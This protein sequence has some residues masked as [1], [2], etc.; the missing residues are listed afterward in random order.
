MRP[1]MNIRTPAV[2][3]VSLALIS[4][5]SGCRPVGEAAGSATRTVVTGHEGGAYEPKNTSRYA[6]ENDV[7]FVDMDY[8]T[9][10][11]VTCSGIQEHTLDDGRLE[12]AANLRNRLSRRI[13]VQ[14]QCVFKDSQGFA[15]DDSATWQDLIL[16]EAGQ[17]TVRFQSLNDK[18]KRYTLRV[19][20]A[21]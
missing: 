16:T 4:V 10:R 5:T 17:E 13:Q 14:V 6:L 2:L 21:H 12:V 19:R 7:R 20:E 1:R 15:V 9:Q 8:R 11:S 3:A 18:A